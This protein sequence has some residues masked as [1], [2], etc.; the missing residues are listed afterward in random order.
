MKENAT[1]IQLGSILFKYTHCLIRL[2]YSKSRNS[3]LHQETERE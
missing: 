3:I 2:R 1:Y